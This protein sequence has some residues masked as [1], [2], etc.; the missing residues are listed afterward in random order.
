MKLLSLLIGDKVVCNHEES[1]I[2][3]SKEIG[4][5]PRTSKLGNWY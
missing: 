4:A 3:Q 1:P 2:E 5:N